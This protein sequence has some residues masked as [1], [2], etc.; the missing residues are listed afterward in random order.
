M[1]RKTRDEDDIP[2]RVLKACGITKLNPVQ[3][4]ALDAGLLV[5]DNDCGR[6]WEFFSN[7]VVFPDIARRGTVRHMI[8][9]ALGQGK[10]YLALPRLAKTV[11]NQANLPPRYPA[12]ITESVMDAVTALQLQLP[13]AAI[14]GTGIAHHLLPLL[15][16][17][18]YLGILPQNDEASAEAVRL[19]KEKLPQARVIEI[20]WLETEKDLNDLY[21][22]RGKA[23]ARSIL[24]KALHKVGF[25]F[26]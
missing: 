16:R 2:A 14:N 11:W 17:R 19:W 22:G 20:P 6:E 12:I 23:A 10:K 3:K 21:T 15:Q 25:E 8:G 9:R 1:T 18:K 4:L 26:S 13:F 5:R 7:R 24:L